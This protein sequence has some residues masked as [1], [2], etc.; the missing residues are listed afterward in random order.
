MFPTIEA[1]LKKAAAGEMVPEPKLIGEVAK[2]MQVLVAKEQENKDLISLLTDMQTTMLAIEAIESPLL[3]YPDDFTSDDNTVRKSNDEVQ[4]LINTLAD[5]DLDGGGH[6]IATSGDTTV[7]RFVEDDHD[8]YMVAKNVQE[9]I[10]TDDDGEE[11]FQ[12]SEAPMVGY[13]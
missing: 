11:V 6:V 2:L 12:T 5:Y 4:E 7:I 13:L 8:L 10:L 9:A 3:L 1:M